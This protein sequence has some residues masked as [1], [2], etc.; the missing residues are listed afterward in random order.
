MTPI[1]DLSTAAALTAE[2][3]VVRTLG[4]GCQV[5]IGAFAEASDSHLTLRAI[6]AS[7]DGS[8][9]LRRE[10][11]RPLDD[12]CAL[13]VA[14]AE[15]LLEDGAGPLLDLARASHGEALDTQ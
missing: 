4:G 12:A 1:N 5:P 3:A 10:A 15:D 2:R 13:G 11:T 9:L 6:V 14:T 7:L 8:R